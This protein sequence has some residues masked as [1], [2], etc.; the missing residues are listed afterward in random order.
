M[1]RQKPAQASVFLPEAEVLLLWR[2]EGKRV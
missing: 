1:D 2:F